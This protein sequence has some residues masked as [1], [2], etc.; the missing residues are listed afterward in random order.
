MDYSFIVIDDGELDCFVV[1]K[2]ISQAFP[3]SPISTF[4][5]AQPV[6]ENIKTGIFENQNFRVVILLDLNMPVMN[7]FQFLDEFEKLP[8]ETKDN[9][10]IIILSST[11]NQGDINKLLKYKVVSNFIEKP[12]NKNLLISLIEEIK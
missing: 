4:R 6:L 12:L 8:E 7:G 2:I 1:K 5:N 9:Y 3:Q 11:K 10:R